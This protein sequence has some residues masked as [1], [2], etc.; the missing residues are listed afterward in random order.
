MPEGTNSKVDQKSDVPS[1][2]EDGQSLPPTITD[3]YLFFYGWNGSHPET[4]LDQYFPSRFYDPDA[5]GGY[6]DDDDNEETGKPPGA[7]TTPQYFPTT[8]QYMMYWKAL[9]MGDDEMALKIADS[10]TPAEAKAMGR[11]VSGMLSHMGLTEMFRQRSADAVQASQRQFL[12]LLC[13]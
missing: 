1:K 13:N 3:K 10:K 12:A 5:T 2:L 11:Q 9:L 7:A 4:C 6:D 8:E